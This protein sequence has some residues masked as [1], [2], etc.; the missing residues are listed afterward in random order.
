MSSHEE[1]SWPLCAQAVSA[2]LLSVHSIAPA[3]LL[4]SPRVL[5]LAT[6]LGLAQLRDDKRGSVTHTGQPD[7]AGSGPGSS[8][9]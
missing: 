1:E 5:S 9:F 2:T 3:Q 7:R 8:D 6:S 4:G